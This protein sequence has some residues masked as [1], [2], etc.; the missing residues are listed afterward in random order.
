MIP[1][2][3]KDTETLGKLQ[4]Q[5]YSIYLSTIV[6]FLISLI[7]GLLHLI[8]LCYYEES[9]VPKSFRFLRQSCGHPA[10][11]LRWDRELQTSGRFWGQPDAEW[12][13]RPLQT[14]AAFS[15]IHGPRCCSGAGSEPRGKLWTSCGP[16]LLGREHD[17]E[18]VCPPGRHLPGWV[19]PIQFVQCTLNNR[20]F[21]K[22]PIIYLNLVTVVAVL[23]IQ[24]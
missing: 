13:G 3:S 5:I 7:N 14:P 20:L 18:E 23:V 1:V 4:I 11:L 6:C 15:W 22:C 21:R 16:L 8:F 17:K 2:N 24:L 12:R 9:A 19:C 10:G